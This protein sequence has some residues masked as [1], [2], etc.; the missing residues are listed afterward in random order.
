MPLLN[1]IA[2][3]KIRQ[4]G[5]IVKNESS[6]I[7]NRVQYYSL[8]IMHDVR[9]MLLTLPRSACWTPCTLCQ[10]C[11]SQPSLSAR[12]WTRNLVCIC[13]QVMYVAES[14]R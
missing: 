14:L 10:N 2:I 12:I 11:L 8:A 4:T 9:V 5:N 7:R 6:S 1:T 13:S 3:T